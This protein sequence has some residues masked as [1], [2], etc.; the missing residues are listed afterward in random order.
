ML[1][2]LR[3]RVRKDMVLVHLVER[4]G[5]ATEKK[6]AEVWWFCYAWVVQLRATSK[7]TRSK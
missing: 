2:Q 4:Q 7:R 5:Q 1:V 3:P 6:D